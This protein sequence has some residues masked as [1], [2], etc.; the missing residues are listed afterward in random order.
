[1][2]PLLEG[3]RRLFPEKSIQSDVADTYFLVEHAP[4][5]VYRH[6][7]DSYLQQLT[8]KSLG[9]DTEVRLEVNLDLDRSQGNQIEGIR[10]FLAPLGVL[11]QG[12][13]QKEVR[14]FYFAD[15]EI[16]YYR[17]CYGQAKVSCLEIEARHAQSIED[18]QKA[19][20]H[21]ETIL[22]LNPQKRS[23]ASLLELLVVPTLSEA[24]QQKVRSMRI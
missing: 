23:H 2:E 9:S 1:M 5:S 13:L 10:A 15:V 21:W 8:V 7:I 20:L 24:L 11:W 6:R 4:Y 12:T 22:G 14:A 16:V 17:A 19:L 18:A 3:L